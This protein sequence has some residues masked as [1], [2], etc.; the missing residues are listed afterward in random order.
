V[1]TVKTKAGAKS[2]RLS[3]GKRHASGKTARLRLKQRLTRVT[4]T[5]TLKDG[6][7]TSQ[8]LTFRRC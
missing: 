2:V 3:A 8:R 5:V 1:L 6:R 4:F 7:T